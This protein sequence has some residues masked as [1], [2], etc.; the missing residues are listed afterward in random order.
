MDRKR[1]AKDYKGFERGNTVEIPRN[2]I[3]G[4]LHHSQ[5]SSLITLQTAA[6]TDCSV[7]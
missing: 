6:N 1:K 5:A 2:F 3:I 4:S 7:C